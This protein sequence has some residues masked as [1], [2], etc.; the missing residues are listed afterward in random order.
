MYILAAEILGERPQELPEIK[1]VPDEYLTYQNILDHEI[2]TEGASNDFIINLE[3]FLQQS[4]DEPGITQP[5]ND[6]PTPLKIANQALTD[7]TGR[8]ILPNYHDSVNAISAINSTVSATTVGGTVVGGTVTGGTAAVNVSDT[9]VNQQNI[10]QGASSLSFAKSLHNDVPI[11]GL[12]FNEKFRAYWDR[13]ADRLYKIRH[14]MNIEG[15]VRQLPLFQ[16]P[17]D[18]GL[19]IKAKAAGLNLTDIA[20]F[21]AKLPPYR[22]SFLVEKAKSYAATVQGFGSALLS[23]L[24]KKDAEELN[25]LRQIHEQNILKL[26]KQV[27]KDNIKKAQADLE[28]AQKMLEQATQRRDYYNNLVINDLNI[29]EIFELSSSK[30]SADYKLLERDV[31]RIA[32]ATYLVPQLGSLFALKYG[33]KELGDSLKENGQNGF[34]QWLLFLVPCLHY[35]V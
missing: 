7:N 15:V 4:N 12:P 11:F 2:E 19:L 13:T 6:K 18:P 23:A 17:I 35:L 34:H 16:P 30:R 26:T 14:C 31:R 32:F 5:A 33:G 25:L 21:N 24:E 22:F 29:W 20:S 10:Q 9:T 28:G 27:K 3:N 1:T 8:D